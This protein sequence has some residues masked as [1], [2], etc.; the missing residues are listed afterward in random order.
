MSNIARGLPEDSGYRKEALRALKRGWSWKRASD[1]WKK[2][3][4]HRLWISAAL[5][6]YREA[7]GDVP[8]LEID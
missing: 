7:G 8:D 6:A 3:G 5:R 2:R 4:R 1:A